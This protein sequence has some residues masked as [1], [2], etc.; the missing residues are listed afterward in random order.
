MKIKMMKNLYQFISTFA[1]VLLIDICLLVGYIFSLFSKPNNGWILLVVI[2]IVLL[3]YF[4]AGLY[5]IAQNI[6]INEKGI[7]IRVFNKV[8]SRYRLEDIEYYTIQNIMKNPAISIKIR[9]Q[10]KTINIDKRKKALSILQFYK[11]EKQ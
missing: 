7:E 3:L 11:V 5:W 1:V 4:G 2:F 8:I 10:I 6:I 9:N